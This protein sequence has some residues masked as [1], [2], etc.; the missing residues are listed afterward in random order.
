MERNQQKLVILN[1]IKTT[2][3][4]ITTF[5]FV[6]LFDNVTNSIFNK[7]FFIPIFRNRELSTNAE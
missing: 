3:N 4:T 2:F 5:M 7:M 1:S 6:N